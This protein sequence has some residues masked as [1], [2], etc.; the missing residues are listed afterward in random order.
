LPNVVQKCSTF[1]Q[2]A[3]F[4]KNIMYSEYQVNSAKVMM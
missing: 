2:S 3:D 4:P 1:G